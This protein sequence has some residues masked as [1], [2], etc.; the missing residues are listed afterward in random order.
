MTNS[1]GNIYANMQQLRENENGTLQGG[2]VSITGGR[3][4]IIIRDDVPPPQPIITDWQNMIAC[5]SNSACSNYICGGST[6]N[7]GPGRTWTDCVNGFC[8]VAQPKPPF[9]N[10]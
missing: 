3:Y 6:N 4:R 1:F 5:W 9:S 2:F 7:P 8:S 10:E